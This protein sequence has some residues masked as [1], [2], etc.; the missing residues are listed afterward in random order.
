MILMKTFIRWQGN[1]SKHINKIIK[2]IPDNFNI[3][4][5]PFVGSGALLLKLEPEKWIIN[6]MNKDLINIWKNVK[7]NPEKII[8]IIE[9]FGKDFKQLSKSKQLNYC[10]E[11]TSKIE[12]IPYN[13]ERAVMYV[14]MKQCVYMGNI[15]LNNQFYF[16]SLDLNVYNNYYPFLKENNYKNLRDVSEYINETNGKIYN[17][18][19]KY[20]LEKAQKG[21]FVFLDPPYI[22][23]NYYGFNYNKNEIIDEKFLNELYKELRK[24][25]KKSIKWMMTQADTKQ[26][27]EIFK[28]YTIKK[29]KVLTVTLFY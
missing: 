15:I 24:L 29:F 9:A 4:I 1:K 22:E 20:V 8:K 16:T 14:L 28:E 11:L 27:K 5:E 19:Y 6:D 23:N 18:D 17:K 13:I 3:Y 2:Y 21:D 25:D 12:Q 26:V 10:R 7:E